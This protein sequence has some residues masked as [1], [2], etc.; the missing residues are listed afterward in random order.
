MFCCPWLPDFLFLLP[1]FPICAYLRLSADPPPFFLVCG[2]NSF[3]VYLRKRLFPTYAELHVRALTARRSS[4]GGISGKTADTGSSS[5]QDFP[6]I[7]PLRTVQRVNRVDRRRSQQ[8]Q[9]E[10]SLETLDPRQV[11]MLHFTL[12]G[13]SLPE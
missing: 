6:P 11:F 3:C 8:A 9:T 12:R 13:L 10:P 2:P 1:S 7:V 5:S 4:V